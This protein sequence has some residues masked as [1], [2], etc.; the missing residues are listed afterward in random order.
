[1]ADVITSANFLKSLKDIVYTYSQMGYDQYP[2]MAPMMFQVVDSKDKYEEIVSGFTFTQ[3]QYKPEGAPVAYQSERQAEVIRAHQKTYGLGFIVTFEEKRYN[4]AEILSKRRAS[5]L[6]DAFKR[7]RNQNA[8][9]VFNNAFTSGFVFANRALVSTA[10]PG[11]GFT[12]QNTLTVQ[13]DFNYESFQ[14]LDVIIRTA[15]DISGNKIPQTSKLLM[16]SPNVHH[17]V[18]KVFE[19]VQGFAPD[20]AERNRNTVSDLITKRL[21][22]P[23]L[24][25]TDAWF[26]LTDK[27][28]DQGMIMFQSIKFFTDT[29]NDADTFN[30][31]FI[32]AEAYEFTC[33]DPHAVYGVQGA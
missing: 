4:K 10:H 3:P 13:V 28:K 9:D 17:E 19:P 16:H 27:P 26:V 22:N 29:D 30:M 21:S 7:G 18:L 2:D 33:A 25:D 32:G 20:T 5:R 1:M 23:Y 11:N 8:T 31:K 14:D 24:T 12:Y 6:G 15:T